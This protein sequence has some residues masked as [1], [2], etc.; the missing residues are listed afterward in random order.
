MMLMSEVEDSNIVSRGGME[1]LKYLRRSAKNFMNAGGMDNPHALE[2]L[3]RM[4]QDFVERNL[5]PGGSADL[6]SLAIF[7]G[8]MENIL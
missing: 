8:K 3:K 2:E 7:L 6:L 4:N 1:S 5:S